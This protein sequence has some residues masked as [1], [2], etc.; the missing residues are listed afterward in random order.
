MSLTKPTVLLDHHLKA[1]KM[2][3]MLRG[4]PMRVS[5]VLTASTASP[6]A[7]PAARLKLSETAGNCA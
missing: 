7:A 5:M 4:M 2:P 1:L 3:T 6:S